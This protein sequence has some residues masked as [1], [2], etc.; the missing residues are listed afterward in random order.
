M[1][2]AKHLGLLVLLC[3]AA[4]ARAQTPTPTPPA[5]EVPVVVVNATNPTSDV[6]LADLRRMLTGERRFW[7]GNVQVR[8][9]LREPGSRGSDPVI[10]GLLKMTTA[11]FDRMW[12]TKEFRGELVG[13]PEFKLS[14]ASVCQYVREHPGGISII[15]TKTLPP[16]VKI[17]SV[18]GKLPGQAGYPLSRA[19][20]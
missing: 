6:S 16:D 9:V 15:A 14:D 7:R 10:A 1:K 18:E 4:C 5:A 11:E 13:F 17:L 19:A 12:R 2:I 3:S 20:E 8:L